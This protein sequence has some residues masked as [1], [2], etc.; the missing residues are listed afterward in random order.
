MSIEKKIKELKTRNSYIRDL[1]TQQIFDIIADSLETI[2]RTLSEY[3][4]RLKSLES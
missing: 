2:Q 3:E 4:A 1:D